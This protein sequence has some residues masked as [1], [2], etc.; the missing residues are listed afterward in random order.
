MIRNRCLL[1]GFLACGTFANAESTEDVLRRD[2]LRQA[3][4]KKGRFM[5]TDVYNSRRPMPQGAVVKRLRVVAVPPKTQ[6]KM[7][8]PEIGLTRDDPGKCV[9]G[10]VPVEADGS[11]SRLVLWLDLYGQY[12]GHFNAWQ[13][14][15]LLALRKEWSAI[16]LIE[17]AQ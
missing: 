8:A 12:E 5:V 13:E 3:A 7:N 15:E 10:T 6:P 11:A 1:L 4:L 16:G 17:D 9:L 2:W 14:A